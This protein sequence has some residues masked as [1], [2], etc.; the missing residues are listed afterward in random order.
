[1]ISFLLKDI[2]FKALHEAMNYD[3]LY[4]VVIKAEA[5]KSYISDY[6]GEYG[7]GVRK[8]MF[9]V[10][11]GA[12][13][14]E[15]RKNVLKY[16]SA[17]CKSKVREMVG[18]NCEIIEPDFTLPNPRSEVY[19]IKMYFVERVKMLSKFNFDYCYK[20]IEKRKKEA[21]REARK[22]QKEELKDVMDIAFG[23]YYDDTKSYAWNAEYISEKTGIYFSKGM[24]ARLAKR[25]KEIRDS[26]RVFANDGILDD[27]YK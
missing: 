2:D 9:S 10:R 13:S 26:L 20:V 3:S 18:E 7:K 23:N 22:R 27:R 11:K 24:I 19:P 25:C 12:N 14:W 15:T 1:M 4:Y 17:V 5:G 16:A 6:F 8:K 21:E